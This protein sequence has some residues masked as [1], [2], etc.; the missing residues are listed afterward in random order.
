MSRSC[1]STVLTVFGHTHQVIF[2]FWPT[3][4]SCGASV[5][6]SASYA[7]SYEIV[8][9]SNTHL[10]DPPRIWPPAMDD[11]NPPID[12]EGDEMRGTNDIIYY[13]VRQLV[14]G[15]PKVPRSRPA[16]FSP[17]AS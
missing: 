11:N 14:T 3:F 13:R 15:C 6:L 8:L 2:G 10:D 5:L 4:G 9:A 7:G 12:G 1:D 16:G 17:R